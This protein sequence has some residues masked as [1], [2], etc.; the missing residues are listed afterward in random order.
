MQLQSITYSEF[1]GH[2][3]EWTLEPLVLGQVNLIVGKNA[4][5]KT[6]ALNIV[7]G[8][9]NIL[10]GRVDPQSL[11][12]SG[13]WDSEF[14][15]S[16]A[17]ADGQT[18]TRFSISFENQTVKSESLKIGRRT[19]LSRD[20]SG[21]G[22]I[23]AEK[24]GSRIGFQVSPNQIVSVS[25]RDSL[26]HPFLDELFRWGSSVRHVLFGTD[27]GRSSVAVIVRAPEDA[28]PAWRDIDNNVVIFRRA[29]DE[30]KSVYKQGI[31]DDMSAIGYDCTDIGL[32][33]PP[34]LENVA[35]PPPLVMFV[36]ERDLSCV[37]S[38]QEMSVGM[39]RALS[40]LV[41]LNAGA[42]AD[43][44]HVLLID[45]IG[46]GLDFER[47]RRL[48]EL[49]VE[50]AKRHSFQL[51]MTTN[52]RF[53]MNAVPLEYWTA[54]HRVGN[55]VRVFNH[56]NSKKRFDEFKDLGLNNF[57]FFSGKHFLDDSV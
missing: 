51:V 22:D 11:Y 41:S 45:D 28:R 6:R 40:I 55:H 39:Y 38:Q 10:A 56:R 53:I 26:Q 17:Q 24:V 30:F 32:M 29:L 54:L 31:L 44:F 20:S 18:K 15:S 13:E 34:G 36:K 42:L 21:K 25:R 48:I 43:I 5:G 12:L 57:D 52:D 9:S 1:V 16:N 37:T 19:R 46:E 47:S 14:V 3:R 35:S 4:S 8:L 7:A 33:V 23:F 49:L 2:D 27:G 50:R